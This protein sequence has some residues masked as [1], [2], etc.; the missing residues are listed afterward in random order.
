MKLDR[1]IKAKTQGE[2]MSALHGTG[3]AFYYVRRGKRRT[4]EIIHIGAK[5]YRNVAQLH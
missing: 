5:A 1:Y 4:A 2:I 3:K